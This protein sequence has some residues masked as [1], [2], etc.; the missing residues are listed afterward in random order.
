MVCGGCP[1]KITAPLQS[2]VTG[3]GITFSGI[4]KAPAISNKSALMQ[5]SQHDSA[6]GAPDLIAPR[7][8]VAQADTAWDLFRQGGLRFRGL[9][10]RRRTNNAQ[11][12]AAATLDP[13]RANTPERLAPAPVGRTMTLP[14]PTC[15]ALSAVML[16]AACHAPPPA[17]W[18]GYAEGNHVRIASPLA[19]AL[20]ELTVQAGQQVALTALRG[21]NGGGFEARTRV[22][23][24]GADGD[25]GDDGDDG[26]VQA[27]QPGRGLHLFD[28]G[29]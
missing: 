26:R 8:A 5:Y 27:C 2:V 23:A 25:D 15:S 16:L 21:C 7:F 10:G 1:K 9:P 14:I 11:L 4:F 17:G 12:D 24:D 20:T 22:R 3:R 18:S 13:T 6:V 29:A 19:D 28:A